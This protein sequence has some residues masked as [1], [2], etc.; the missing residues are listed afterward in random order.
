MSGQLPDEDGRILEAARICARELDGLCR[1]FLESFHSCERDFLRLGDALHGF[2]ATASDVSRRCAE[3]AELTSGEAVSSATSKLSSHLEHMVAACAGSTVGREVAGLETIASVGGKLSENMRDFTRLV[4][5]LS[6]LGISTRIESARLGSQGLGFSTLA[7]D[8]E[9]LAGKIESSSERISSRAIELTKQCHEASK[10]IV[11]MEN[12][13]KNY[14]HSAMELL[15]ADLDALDK[16]RESSN[17]TAAE[18]SDEAA[19]LVSSV[20]EA[21]LSMQFHDII[22]QQLEHVAEAT[23]EVRSMAAAGPQTAAGHDA[24]D[25]EELAG[26]MRSVLTLQHSQL[27]NAHGRF[28]QA[29]ESLCSSLRDIAGRVGNMASKAGGLGSGDAGQRG[30]LG[31][32]EQEI[33]SIA[34]A[35]KDYA[36][37]ETRMSAVMGE[38]GGSIREMASSVSEIEEVGSEIELIALNASV[39]AAHTGEEG[40][41]LGVLASAIQKLSVDARSQTDKIA[42][43]LASV[44]AGS[45]DV[46]A[47]AGASVDA[48]TFESSIAELDA[49]MANLKALDEHVAQAALS[50]QKEASRL[51]S[52]I[53]ATVSSLDFQQGLLSAMAAAE[54]RLK[55]LSGELGAVL[56]KDLVVTHSPQLREMLERY[57]MDAERLVHEDVLGI[58]PGQQAVLDGGDYGDNVELF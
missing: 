27:D 6:M 49:E 11:E 53:E 37:L 31:Q 20:S 1:G 36:T 22:R 7:D 19:S 44:D 57:T 25:W 58:A 2:N 15:E 8:V 55:E 12:T 38:V 23:S 32:I 40:K 14:S 5:H 51:S 13:R 41:A 29:M 10:S 4:K 42:A 48:K 45:L 50:V 21:V 34:Q 52:D 18:I 46:E 47:I 24:R 16:L 30:I 35:L 9:K 26:W 43:L 56:P 17:R 28:S 3:L 39:R 54:D 33:R